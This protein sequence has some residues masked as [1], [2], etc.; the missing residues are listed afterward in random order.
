MPQ[1]LQL[2][3]KPRQASQEAREELEV[4]LFAFNSFRQSLSYTSLT[5]DRINTEFYTTSRPS[6][7]TIATQI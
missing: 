1:V 4:R 5:V 3:G 2:K 7:G 6:T